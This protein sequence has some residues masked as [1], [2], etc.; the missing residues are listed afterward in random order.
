MNELMSDTEQKWDA[1]LDGLCSKNL[2]VHPPLRLQDKLGY[3]PRLAALCVSGRVAKSG[4][5]R[6]YAPLTHKA[7]SASDCPLS[8]R[9]VL[10]L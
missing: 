6:K 5:V 8:P 10:C 9:R 2:S 7:G 3:V 4:C 1:R